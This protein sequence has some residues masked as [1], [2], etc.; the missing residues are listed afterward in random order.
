MT[1]RGADTAGLRRRGILPEQVAGERNAVSFA[2]RSDLFREG[3]DEEFRQKP[4]VMVTCRRRGPLRA[5]VK[6]FG[7]MFRKIVSETLPEKFRQ[8]KRPRRIRRPRIRKRHQIG[9]APVVR[10]IGEDRRNRTTEILSELPPV[11]VVGHINEPL[12]RSG[13]EHVQVGVLVEPVAARL[14]FGENFE[15][16]LPAG[17]ISAVKIPC[18]GAVETRT[19]EP[20][21]HRMRR[22]GM[23]MQ[24]ENP[25]PAGRIACHQPPRRSGRPAVLVVETGNQSTPLRF[26]DGGADAVEPLPPEVGRRQSDPGMHEESAQPHRLEFPDLAPQLFRLQSAV[27]APER[28]SPVC[29]AGC[30][31]FFG[32]RFGHSHLLFLI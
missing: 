25:R 7:Q 10:L 12:H 5:V 26:F 30:G 4:P 28:L 1:H 16:R 17:R 18:D 29:R 6:E 21:T 32:K 19:P 22:T 2:P 11:S 9:V 20:E 14:L 3:I 13:V 15:A 27:P 23:G 31:K 8:A 24:I